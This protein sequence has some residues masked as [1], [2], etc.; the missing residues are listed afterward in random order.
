M[1]AAILR[2]T[3]TRARCLLI[4]VRHLVR[5]TIEFN[6]RYASCSLQELVV[7]YHSCL[8]E[9]YHLIHLIGE[10]NT[11]SKIYDRKKSL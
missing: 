3:C 9:I 1:H 6:Y 5:K 8:N 10:F 4:I 11:L 2:V 7:T